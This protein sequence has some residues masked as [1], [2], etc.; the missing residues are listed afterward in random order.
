MKEL[1]SV[2]R[3]YDAVQFLAGERYRELL[4]PLLREAGLEIHIPMEGLRIGEQLAWLS[5]H[6]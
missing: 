5:G 4:V 3:R 1:L 2:A 6:R